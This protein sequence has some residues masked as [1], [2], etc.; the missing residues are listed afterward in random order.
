MKKIITSLLSVA[1][2]A[3][4]LFGVQPTAARAQA[5]PQ[6]QQTEYRLLTKKE[7]SPYVD[8]E[9]AVEHGHVARFYAEEDLNTIVY[10]N[11][12]GTKTAY[13]FDYDVKYVAEDGTIEDKDIELVEIN[14]GYDVKKSD[15]SLNIPDNIVSGLEFEHDDG[16]IKLTPVRET[17]FEEAS[18]KALAA[19]NSP[20]N[21]I[22]DNKSNEVYYNKAFGNGTGLRYKPTMTGIKEKIVLDTYTGTSSWKFVAQTNGLQP[23][24]DDNGVY[25][26]AKSKD[27]KNKYSLGNVYTYDSVGNYTYGTM[28]VRE[29]KQGE[30]YTIELRVDEDFLTDENTVYPVHVDPT[31]TVKGSSIECTTVYSA[32][33]TSNYFYNI[34]MHVGH[35][36]DA[37]SNQDYGTARVVM[38]MDSLINN[39][40]FY[41]Y[42][43]EIVSATLSLKFDLVAEGREISIHRISNTTWSPVTATWNSIGNSYSTAVD[44]FVPTVGI[45][46]I[47]VTDIVNSWRE[48][49]KFL[50]GG[51]MFKMETEPNTEAYHEISNRSNLNLT[52]KPL[53]SI[54]YDTDVSEHFQREMLIA[55]GSGKSLYKHYIYENYVTFTSM[56]P[57]IARVDSSTGVVTGVSEGTTRIKILLQFDTNNNGINTDSTDERITLYCQ[58]YVQD[59]SET[60]TT[61]SRKYYGD[62]GL[63]WVRDVEESPLTAGEV[64][65]T[66]TCECDYITY[67]T[68]LTILAFSKDENTYDMLAESFLQNGVNAGLSSLIVA[69]AEITVSFQVIIVGV[70]VESILALGWN[71]LS[72]IKREEF[73]ECCLAMSQ[74]DFIKIEYTK[75]WGND[76]QA[77][78]VYT[79]NSNTFENPVSGKY[80]SWHLDEFAVT[81]EPEV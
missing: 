36:V 70:V 52:A 15:I 75:T 55:K 30:L 81:E 35:Y 61:S 7:L 24:I 68:A 37:N 1:M 54:R 42:M 40:T 16:Y 53:L 43:D 73:Q 27:S 60:P 63:A 8:Y 39:T 23:Y 33:P 9:N 64:F 78:S 80:G 56:S 19:Q 51:L 14:G 26:F 12:D 17:L 65:G 49:E 69:A 2:F 58:V 45:N 38:R 3:T 47:D 57:S 18:N 21:A 11:M 44:A 29:I 62:V 67:S 72:N 46:H 4:T 28:S 6:E 76:G 31:L 34:A 59:Y 74:G 48:N 66:Y 22:V 71:K 79:P 77:Y 5:L 41:E 25:Y 32:T 10:K 20:Q 50:K 13:I